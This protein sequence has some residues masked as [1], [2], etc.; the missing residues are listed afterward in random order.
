MAMV[1]NLGD[2]R[3]KNVQNRSKIDPPLNKY[4]NPTEE[5]LGLEMKTMVSKA[6]DESSNFK[7]NKTQL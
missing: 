1:S 6:L 3:V 7:E 2:F 4:Y 5:S